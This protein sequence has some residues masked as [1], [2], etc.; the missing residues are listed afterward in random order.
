M[1]KLFYLLAIACLAA[2][3][4]G[5]NEEEKK[6]ET[7]DPSSSLWK[8][9]LYAPSLVQVYAEN[10][11]V[12]SYSFEFDGNMRVTS[13]L[14]KDEI[15]GKALLDL[16]YTYSGKSDMSVSG[17][18]YSTAAAKTVNASIDGKTVTYKGD[19]DNARQYKTTY[20]ANGT[21][22]A[23]DAALEFAPTSGQYSSLGTYSE[24][25]KVSSG[26]VTSATLGA[27]IT[28]QSSKSAKLESSKEL[29]IEYTYSDKPDKQ[30]FNV[31]LMNC[32]FPVWFAKELPGCK[33]LI[34]GMK[35]KCG[36]VT[37]PQSFKVEYTFDSG[38][39]ILTAT[40]KDY[41]DSELVL[42]RVYKLTY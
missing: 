6:K 31:F 39:D 10:E 12:E 14:R 1:K 30:N 24:V 5:N 29:T 22:T 15:A 20:D 25:Y 16:A 40:R 36:S 37:L 7:D 8:M 42:T 32:E 35:M 33:N 26:N 34:S 41:N 13:L 11:L 9:Q 3:C 2:S 4:G 17:T 27:D 38:G 28:S 18:F 23:T 19:W 21:V